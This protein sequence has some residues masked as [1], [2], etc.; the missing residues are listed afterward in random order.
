MSEKKEIFAGIENY[1]EAKVDTS[2]ELLKI[3]AIG[4]LK[5]LKGISEIR[6]Q[7]EAKAKIKTFDGVTPEDIVLNE[8]ILKINNEWDFP[9][10]DEELC[11]CR[12]V[13]TK[14]VDRAIVMGAHDPKSV[15]LCTSASTSCGAC[16]EDVEKILEFRLKSK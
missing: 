13:E 3:S 11:H 2:E 5:F 9:Y 7:A 10:K 15:S 16:K 4:S 8:L 14:K 6:I 12:A 1:L